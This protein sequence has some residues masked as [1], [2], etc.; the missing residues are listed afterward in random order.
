M[1]KR[2]RKQPTTGR[3]RE[4]LCKFDCERVAH[5]EAEKERAGERESKPIYARQPSKNQSPCGGYAKLWY[6]LFRQSVSLALFRMRHPPENRPAPRRRSVQRLSPHAATALSLTALFC[7]ALAL[8]QPL[9]RVEKLGRVNHG[10]LLELGANFRSDQQALLGLLADILVVALPSLLFLILPVIA[11]SR[12]LGGTF[13]GRSLAFRAC[14]F[15]KQW[16]MPEVFV[17]SILVAFLKIDDLAN[18]SAASG[19][20]FLVAA[21]LLLTYLLQRVPLPEP[22]HP[23]SHTAALALLVSACIFLIPANILP[24]MVVSTP[25]GSTSSTLL[26][27]VANLADHGLW[28]IAAI[29]FI[30]SILVP[31]GK[32]GGLIW[33]LRI[34][35]R[36]I[37]SPQGVRVHRV[38]EYVG[39]WSMLDIFLI[40]TLA[41]LVDFRPLASIEPGPAAPAFAAA[42]ILTALAVR[43]FDSHSLLLDPICRA[44]AAQHH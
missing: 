40:G 26:T 6:A 19:F 42:V 29:V 14:A 25:R 32:I 13:P 17:L 22:A 28:G 21:T 4:E 35:K 33:L 7:W 9:A 36:R 15:A 38:L 34:S 5:S 27:G 44:N 3:R 16:A 41:G 37:H 39:R 1:A 43:R 24:M 23:K 18:A 30:A 31:F 11:L 8:W 20:Y 12:L 2:I 10:R